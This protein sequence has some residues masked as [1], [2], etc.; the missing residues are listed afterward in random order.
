MNLKKILFVLS[1]LLLTVACKKEP[2][3]YYTIYGETSDSGAEYLDKMSHHESMRNYFMQM[4]VIDDK[5]DTYEYGLVKF[6]YSSSDNIHKACINLDKAAYE[7]GEYSDTLMAKNG[8]V[9]YSKE[10]RHIVDS[11][12]MKVDSLDAVIGYDPKK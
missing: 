10:A 12:I 3:V 5:F 9:M 7:A 6:L 4:A 2:Y 1:L 8:A 11:L